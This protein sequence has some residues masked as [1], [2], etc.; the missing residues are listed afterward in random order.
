[1]GAGVQGGGIGIM[2]GIAAA[3]GTVIVNITETV[4]AI[5]MLQGRIIAALI[6][7]LPPPGQRVDNS[8]HG[9]AKRPPRHQRAKRGACRGP[10]TQVHVLSMSVGGLPSQ[11]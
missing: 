1:M 3:I 2:I 11:A 10:A 6:I 4:T 8:S 5:R 7:I 9:T